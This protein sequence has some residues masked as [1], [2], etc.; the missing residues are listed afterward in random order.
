MNSFIFNILIICMCGMFVVECTTNT[1]DPVNNSPTTNAGGNI[2]IENLYGPTFAGDTAGSR[3]GIDED[4]NNNNDNNNDNNSDNALVVEGSN[5]TIVFQVENFDINLNFDLNDNNNEVNLNSS[6]QVVGDS[7]NASQ[8]SQS[9]RKTSTP[10]SRAAV[11]RE[12]LPNTTLENAPTINM[13]GNIAAGN[14]YAPIYDGDTAGN[15]QDIDND[16]N[17]NNDNNNDNNNIN[18]LMVTGNFN[19]ITY[20]VRNIDYNFNI[21]INYNQNPLPDV[22]ADGDFTTSNV[23][24]NMKDARNELLKTIQTLVLSTLQ[25]SCLSCHS[26]NKQ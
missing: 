7:Y 4:N 21:N 24:Q 10:F 22:S 17:N 18:S 23:A 25:D 15:R 11:T 26:Q 20:S 5:N 16:N 9:S 13:G 12:A 6:C 14:Q 8:A 1:S 3:Q 2:A 19:Q